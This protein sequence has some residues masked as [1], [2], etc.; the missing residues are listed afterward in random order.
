MS[1]YYRLKC[2]THDEEE[3]HVRL[4]HGGEA[5]DILMDARKAFAAAHEIVQAAQATGQ[6]TWWLNLE[7][8]LCGP[9]NGLIEWL[10]E[11]AHCDMAIVDEYGEV[12]RRSAREV[13]PPHP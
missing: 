6:F 13:A 7:N 12:I 11:H 2:L 5:L 4:N 1:N 8:C 10:A 9:Y 3:P